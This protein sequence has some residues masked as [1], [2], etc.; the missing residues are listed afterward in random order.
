MEG[1]DISTPGN[2]SDIYVTAP[3]HKAEGDFPI[4]R[5]TIVNNV[6]RS[7]G[8]RVMGRPAEK[9]IVKGNRHLGPTPGVILNEA[10]AEV[11]DNLNYGVTSVFSSGTARRPSLESLI[12]KFV[13]FESTF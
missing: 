9:V 1:Y 3:R 13:P 7:N 2:I 11:T 12:K 6:T 10:D 4:R 8:I 5:V